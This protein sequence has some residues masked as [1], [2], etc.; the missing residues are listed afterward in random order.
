MSRPATALR[1]FLGKTCDQGMSARF[2]AAHQNLLFQGNPDMRR[3]S[4]FVLSNSV[5][6]NRLDAAPAQHPV[7]C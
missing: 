6:Q 3:K 7:R 2:L 5:M 1:L 4:G